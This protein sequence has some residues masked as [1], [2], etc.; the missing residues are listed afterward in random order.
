MESTS[1]ESLSWDQGLA[2]MAESIEPTF[3]YTFIQTNK[4]LQRLQM[5]VLLEKY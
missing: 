1:E 2:R 3:R 5:N 4:W